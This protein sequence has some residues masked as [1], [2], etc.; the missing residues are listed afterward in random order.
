[1]LAGGWQARGMCAK[2]VGRER[3]WLAEGAVTEPACWECSEGG[4][5]VQQV[6][7]GRHRSDLTGPQELDTRILDFT[8]SSG[9]SM[10]H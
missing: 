7:E 6:A 1:M 10:T 4:K 8:F 5:K 2:A 9:D 3:P